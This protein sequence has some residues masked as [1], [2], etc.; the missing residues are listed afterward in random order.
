MV[1]HVTVNYKVFGYTDTIQSVQRP[2]KPGNVREFRCKEKKSGNF[3][4]CNSFL[5]NLEH[6]NFE[7]FLGEH[8]PRPPKQ[9]RTHIKI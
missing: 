1:S 7:N 3:V 4:V 2:G 5:A 8:V 9:S 6:P